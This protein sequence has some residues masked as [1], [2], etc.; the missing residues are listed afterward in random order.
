[1]SEKIDKEAILEDIK[2]KL[3]AEIPSFWK[4]SITLG[5]TTELEYYSK[6]IVGQTFC[7]RQKDKLKHRLISKFV[8]DIKG[9]RTKII[10]KMVKIS[11]T[12][13][14][15]AEAYYPVNDVLEDLQKKWEGLN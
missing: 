9:N 4:A 5:K 15:K 10:E 12:I 7:K 2:N 13:G 6:V 11:E 3:F 1:M 8:N 14:L